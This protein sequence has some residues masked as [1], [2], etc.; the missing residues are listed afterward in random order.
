[1]PFAVTAALLAAALLGLVYGVVHAGDDRPSRRATLVKTGSTA[2][3]ALAGLIGGAPGWIV[4]GLALGS[5]G[6]YALS[7]DG[8]RAFLA[9]MIA[10]ALGHVAYVAAF[11]GRLGEG[12]LPGLVTPVAVAMVALSALTVLWIAP[13][14][15]AFCQPVRAYA[16]VI[17]AMALAA[18]ALP[19]TDAHRAVQV[20]VLA[21]VASD[22]ILALRLFV[23][24]GT[25]IRLAAARTLWPLYWVGQALILWGLLP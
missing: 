22:L 1:M 24:R 21:F 13:R 3:L 25:A 8:D 23:L 16:L 9:G 11:V 7:R 2:L 14:A 20:G 19:P 15:G 18:A 6:D 17:A 4:L 10:F 5:V 12:P